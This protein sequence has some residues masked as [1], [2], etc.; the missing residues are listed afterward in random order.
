[1]SYFLDYNFSELTQAFCKCYCKTQNDEQIYMELKNIKQ[2]ETKW[3]EVYYE[4][5]QKLVHGFLQTPTI[6][7]LPL[8]FKRNYSPI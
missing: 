4:H 1:M 6:N 2:G 5:I 7:N 8:C 3:I